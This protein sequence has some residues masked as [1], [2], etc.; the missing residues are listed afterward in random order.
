MMGKLII[1][2]GDTCNNGNSHDSRNIS[3]TTFVS[4]VLLILLVLAAT[5]QSR[6]AST[7]P[8]LAVFV[9]L[10]LI[11]IVEGQLFFQQ[12]II[13]NARKYVYWVC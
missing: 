10:T 3:D 1:I 5:K 6:R 4:L 2:K 11:A 13:K 8:N 9:I 7:K 12:I